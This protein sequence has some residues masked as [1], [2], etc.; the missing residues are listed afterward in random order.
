LSED[1]VEAGA[2]GVVDTGAPLAVAEPAPP[3]AAPSLRSQRWALVRLV[4]AVTVCF[5]LAVVFHVAGT[6]AVVAAIVAM[7][8]LHE[9]GHF[10][11]A[12]LG[13]MKVTEFFV[14]FGP[15]VWS[16]RRGETTYGVKALP[17]G[18]YVRVVGMTNLE[19]VAPA[20]EARSYRHATFPRRMGVALAGSATHLLLALVLAIALN[21]IWG[22][23]D[24][25]RVEVVGFT[26]LPAGVA[27]PA[28]VAGMRPGDVVVSIDG[29][30][31]RSFSSL[32]TP[33]EAHPGTP[34]RLVVE[35]H[36]RRRSLVATPF[37]DAGMRIDGQLLSPAGHPQ[38]FLGI[39]L[40]HPTVPL[41]VGSSVV[42]GA[43]DLG[44]AMGSTVAILGHLVSPSGIGAYVHTVVNPSAKPSSSASASSPPVRLLSP[45][46][47]VQVAADAAHSGAEDVLVLL[48][49]IN[50]FVGL[51][52]LFPM[53]P[54]DGGHVVIAIYERLRS[55]RRRR[56]HAD[57]S[58]LVAP[59]Y[60]VISALALLFLSAVFLDIT[61][62]IANPFH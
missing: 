11:M 47:V 22:P 7:I 36:G 60:V 23:T 43:E 42:T 34:V 62:P 33:I 9:A 39:E 8:V 26:P 18:G 27:N 45:V 54:F 20:D 52:N 24:P 44:S 17:L 29:H 38:G 37:D 10:V 46:G 4:S 15:R 49:S 21:A 55:S 1:P 25:H 30:P 61:H 50:V 59:T 58:K 5:V 2:E 51:F 40:E 41:G 14:G 56:Y 32:A 53:L 48:F 28:Q 3:E 19:P 35:R 31:V 16:F 13:G 6:V 57:V 12:K